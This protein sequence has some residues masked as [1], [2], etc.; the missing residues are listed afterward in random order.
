ML[1]FPPSIQIREAKK[2]R[3]EP[4]LFVSAPAEQSVCAGASSDDS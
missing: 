3:V 2:L 1:I 4:N